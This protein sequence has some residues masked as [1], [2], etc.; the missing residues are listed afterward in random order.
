MD[1]LNQRTT[2]SEEEGK[3]W[4][5]KYNSKLESD[6]VDERIKFDNEGFDPLHAL[7]SKDLKVSPQKNHPFQNFA[8]F[9]SAMKR[10]GL[11]GMASR[12][13]VSA[14]SVGK[15]KKENV[16]IQ[17]VNFVRKF[18]PHQSKFA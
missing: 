2:D 13:K 18:L 8:M 12:K 14:A 6:F 11:Y 3:V 16:D 7:Y 15:S 4:N 10:V 17:D 5:N 9:E 1:H